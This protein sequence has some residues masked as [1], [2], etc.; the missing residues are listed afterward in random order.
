MPKSSRRKS[1]SRQPIKLMIV[2]HSCSEPNEPEYALPENVTYVTT[3]ICGLATENSDPVNEQFIQWFFDNA[4]VFKR[5]P[6]EIVTIDPSIS[7]NQETTQIVVNHPNQSVI[8]SQYFFLFSYVLDKDDNQIENTQGDFVGTWNACKSGTYI[9]KPRLKK[10]ENVATEPVVT[11]PINGNLDGAHISVAEIKRIY[12]DSIYP[13]ANAVMKR[14]N[15]LLK[16]SG[17]TSFI[18]KDTDTCSIALFESAIDAFFLNLNVFVETVKR[19]IGKTREIRIY[20]PLC[21]T[22][23]YSSNA[24]FQQYRKTQTNRRRASELK[25]QERFLSASL[26]EALKGGR[27]TRKC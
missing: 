18:R 9:M 10:Y 25:I 7:A 20:D 16:S 17:V 5:S 11:I 24:E 21:K 26:L 2:G 19:Q 12:K 22:D 14:V 8:S 13:T 15:V 6:D 1:K 3:G 27:K 23:C 4:I